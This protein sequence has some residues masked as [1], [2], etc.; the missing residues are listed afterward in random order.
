MAVE[1]ER[2]AS[3]S[4]ATPLMERTP[5]YNE[6]TQTSL[7]V[8]RG[9]ILVI[10]VGLLLFIQTTN[11]S[12]LTTAQSDIAADLDAFSETTW[13]SSAYLIAMSSVTPLAGRLCQ[14]FTAR[15]YTLFSVILLSI[16][17]FITAAAQSLPIFLLGRAVSGCGSAGVMVTSFILILD[18]T[19]K[20][21]R[22]L[23]IGLLNV[24]LTT[25]ISCGAVIAGLLTPKY[26]WRL[27]FWIQAPASLI[28]GLVEF[29]AVPGNTVK[30]SIELGAQSNLKKLAKVDYPGALTLTASVFLLLF[31][32]ASPDSSVTVAPLVLSV[33]F[34]SSFLL[35]ESRFTSEPII[36]I[37]V[38]KAKSVLATCVAALISMMARWSILFFTPVY[39]MAV[40]GWSPASAGL[41]LVP[42]NAGFGLGGLLVGWIHIRK[43]SS[44]Y[45]S[46][47]VV[48]LLFALTSFVLALLSTPSSSTVAYV[49]ATFLNGF[50]IGASM[51][52]AL[53]HMLHLTNPDVHYIT[54]S[55]LG[56]FRGSAG[57]FGSAI[58]GGFFQR[59]LKKALE[60]GFGE[61]GLFDKG[62]LVRKLLGSP[63]LVG[64]LTDTEKKVAVESYEHAIK[65][66]ILGGCVLALVSTI[67][68]ACTGWSAPLGMEKG[69]GD[70]VERSSEGEE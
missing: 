19:S 59:E 45:I 68:Q 31:S 22:G 53:S 30:G 55:L 7:S 16:G 67:V 64:R 60:K 65:V 62:E 51:N 14:I 69:D 23:F 21:R 58:G 13:F 38:L 11:I 52:Y 29:F 46:T 27:I 5:T 8:F 37:E 66:L 47:L 34:F 20:E 49:V 18:L 63:A 42:T 25:G 12:M 24:G 61:N 39:A 9:T 10:A 17:L 15:S 40:R 6:E 54:T 26:G 1:R 50:F 44:Y 48:L 56:M 35:I 28:L 4:E 3:P 57:S 33:V 32:L 2:D 41:I 70:D 43:T 36:P